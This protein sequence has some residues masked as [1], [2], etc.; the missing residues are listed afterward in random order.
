MGFSV[1]AST[2]IVLLAAFASI[3]LLYSA[4]SNGFEDVQEA[5]NLEGD[6]ALEMKNADI[7]ITNLSVNE[8]KVP[9]QITVIVSNEGATT[10]SLDETD[11]ILNG[12]VVTDNIIYEITSEGETLAA[13]PD[14]TTGLWQPQETL[15]ITIDQNVTDTRVKFVTGTGVADTE[16]PA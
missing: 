13:G 16:V 3:G 12:S 8:T 10:F 9:D 15:T 4:G 6:R 2:A 7:D 14:G 11:V 5:K 1:S